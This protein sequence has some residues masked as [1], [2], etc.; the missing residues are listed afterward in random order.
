VLSKRASSF[1]DKID[2][3]LDNLTK[4]DFDNRY[5]SLQI[6]LTIAAVLCLVATKYVAGEYF[7]KE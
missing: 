1:L 6:L 4:I 2:K 3:H 5:A 7:D